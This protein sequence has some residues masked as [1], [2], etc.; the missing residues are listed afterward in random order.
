MRNCQDLLGLTLGSYIQPSL[1]FVYMIMQGKDVRNGGEGGGGGFA[2]LSLD[3]ADST[4]VALQSKPCGYTHFLMAP[5][6]SELL[7]CS[8]MESTNKSCKD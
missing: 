4:H 1:E 3:L 2:V 7:W 5:I 6:N 8:H